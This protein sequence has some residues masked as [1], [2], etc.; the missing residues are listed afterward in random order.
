MSSDEFTSGGWL[1]YVICVG[2][3]TNTSLK[4]GFHA[5]W[6]GD[7]T[8]HCSQKEQTT[9]VSRTLSR[10]NK[11]T[12]G[13]NYKKNYQTLF[14]HHHPKVL[15]SGLHLTGRRV[16]FVKFKVKTKKKIVYY[17]INVPPH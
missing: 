1:L 11:C 17:Y 12:E 6:A 5:L 4:F 14:Q 16:S 13:Q 7:N 2:Y 15:L 9:F 3:K 8:D 10:S